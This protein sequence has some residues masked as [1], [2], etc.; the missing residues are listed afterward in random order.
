MLQPVPLKPFFS[1]VCTLELALKQGSLITISVEEL[2]T[3][4]PNVEGSILSKQKGGI[5]YTAPADR[6]NHAFFV[7]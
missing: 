4:T 6:L 2:L 1:F 7:L 5:D 3:G